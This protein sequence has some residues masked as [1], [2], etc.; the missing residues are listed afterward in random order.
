[1]AYGIVWVTRRA[2]TTLPVKIRQALDTEED[3][4][5][6]VTVEGKEICF[7]NPEPFRLLRRAI[8]S[9]G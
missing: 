3:D 7:R 9:G 4:S 6:V 1:M 2:R 5:L 8:P